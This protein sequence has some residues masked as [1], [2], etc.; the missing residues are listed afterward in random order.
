MPLTVG[1]AAGASSS[2]LKPSDFLPGAAADDLIQTDK[3]P[4]ADEQNVGG[5]HRREFLMR[6]LAP[7]LGWNIG[8]GSFKNLEQGLLHAFAG[9]VASDGRVLILAANLVD[10]IDIDDAGLRPAN[11]AIGGLQELQNDVLDVFADVA[12][13]SQRGRIDDGKRNVQHPG[14]RLRHQ[15][16]ARSRRPD[17][18]DV[19]F[20]E[21]N[22]IA[23]SLAVHINSLVVVVNR[24]CQ[25]LLGLFLP[26]YVLIEESL[27]FLRLGKLVGGDAGGVAAR[28][29]SRMEL[30][31]ATHSSQM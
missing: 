9:D 15:G 12:S 28:S 26:D 29:S 14:Q 19:R 22:A 2:A 10:F 8:D 20:R 30:Q 1:S 21:L 7:A 5:V 24:D 17:Q 4:A 6:M 11:V 18:H 31:T 25:L 3:C 27:N 13:F 23:G 16:F